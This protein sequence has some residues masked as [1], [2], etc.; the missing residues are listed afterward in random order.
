MSTTQI[1]R[2]EKCN[3][4]ILLSDALEHRCAPYSTSFLDEWAAHK[5]LS[6]YASRKV[7]FAEEMLFFHRCDSLFKSGECDSLFKSGESGIYLYEGTFFSSGRRLEF[8]S[9]WTM[10]P[11]SG[12]PGGEDG[13]CAVI[14]PKYRSRRGRIVVA[15]ARRTDEAIAA[16][17]VSVPSVDQLNS[18]VATHF[19]PDVACPVQAIVLATTPFPFF[20]RRGQ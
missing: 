20:H 11:N 16:A 4:S 2:R 14:L 8:R 12:R 1:L 5:F 19:A 9:L 17:V 18:I 10:H 15:L 6:F 13:S 7:S 3:A